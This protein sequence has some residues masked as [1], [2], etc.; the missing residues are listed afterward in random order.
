MQKEIDETYSTDHHIFFMSKDS[1]DLIVPQKELND[2]AM[3]SGNAVAIQVLDYLAWLLG[4]DKMKEVSED[5]KCYAATEIAQYPAAY[6]AWL[7][8]EETARSH[9]QAVECSIKGCKIPRHAL[10][11]L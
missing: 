1:T 5:I 9:P 4:A 7:N 2:G 6:T 10:N 8:S 3:P 11:F